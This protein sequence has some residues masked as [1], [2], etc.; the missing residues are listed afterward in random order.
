MLCILTVAGCGRE[1]ST[2]ELIGDL[3]SG[4]EEEGVIASRTLPLGNRDAAKVIPALTEALKHQGSGVRRSSALKLGQ[5]H[6]QAKEAIPALQQ[7]EENDGDAR[8]RE[9]AG[10]ALSR[11]DPKRF[12]YKPK[13]GSAFASKKA[14]KKKR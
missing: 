2:D 13:V 14:S 8:V 11:I 6:E 9:A 1:K 12:P 4:K 10:I 3:K 7:V 5:F